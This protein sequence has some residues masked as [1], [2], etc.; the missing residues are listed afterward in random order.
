MC[1]CKND[2]IFFWF[3]SDL[4]P[5]YISIGDC[6]H[7][8]GDGNWSCKQ[9][10]IT[11]MAELL[12][13]IKKNSFNNIY[14]FQVNPYDISLYHVVYALRYILVDYF[15]KDMLKQV[16]CTRSIFVIIAFRILRHRFDTNSMKS[17]C[18]RNHDSSMLTKWHHSLQHKFPCWM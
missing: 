5:V 9:H 13:Y 8:H 7:M 4:E 17:F 15:A 16:K 18:F 11:A 1:S 12:I 14:C 3:Y 10:L 2:V 6:L